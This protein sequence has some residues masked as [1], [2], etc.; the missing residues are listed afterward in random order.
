MWS[1]VVGTGKDPTWITPKWATCLREKQRDY[2]TK[3][4]SR[5]Y[6]VKDS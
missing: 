3:D 1:P 4:G 2:Q 5:R 6:H